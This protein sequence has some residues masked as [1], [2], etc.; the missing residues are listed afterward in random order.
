MGGKLAVTWATPV[1]TATVGAQLEAYI[2]TKE[3]IAIFQQCVQ[4]APTDSAVAQLPPELI[5][6]VANHFQSSIFQDKLAGWEREI[7][8]CSGICDPI[9]HFD[10]DEIQSLRKDYMQSLQ[11][12]PD[13]LDDYDS[14]FGGY[15]GENHDIV[16]LHDRNV[17]TLL[18]KVASHFPPMCD[19]QFARSRKVSNNK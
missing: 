14:D 7:E 13:D 3:T 19:T 16:G 15:L 12:P 10:P 6:Y 1:D 17:E 8:C 9:D 2:E 11:C 18:S 5:K 4:S